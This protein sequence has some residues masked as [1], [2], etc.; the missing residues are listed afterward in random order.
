MDMRFEFA[1]RCDQVSDA[2]LHWLEELKDNW[3]EIVYKTLIKFVS[4]KVLQPQF[5]QYRWRNSIGL[6]DMHMSDDFM[7]QYFFGTWKD[8]KCYVVECS[9]F[10]YIF[11]KGGIR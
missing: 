2:D 4:W 6:I 7:V 5:P 10:E 1:L 9:G 3:T 11:T 8:H